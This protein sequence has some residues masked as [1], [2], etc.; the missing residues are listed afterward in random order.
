MRYRIIADS[1]CDLPSDF[2]KD[3]GIDFSVVPLKISI[4]GKEFV[5]DDTLDIKAFINAMRL[6]KNT[7][8]ACPSPDAFCAEFKK[9]MHSICITISQMLSGTY[10]SAVLGAS[11]A[12][13]ENPDIKAEVVDSYLTSGGMILMIM[14]LKEYIK[15][16]LDYEAIVEKIKEYQK[17]ICVR[18]VLQ[19]LGNLVKAG[20]MS[21]VA[22]VFASA[23][24]LCPICG[25]NTKGEIKVFEKVRGSK[26]A[27]SHLADTVKEKL[28]KEKDFPVIITHCDNEEQAQSLKDMLLERYGLKNV[29]IFPQR[30]LASFYAAYKGLIMAF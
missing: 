29:S 27:I 23:L 5:D 26:A 14:K 21:R 22:G 25:D 11:L 2:L 19:D 13:E 16:G 1:S 9:N 4:D 20:R 7:G 10:S 6:G 8:T 28:E 17:T 15:E 12:K 24:S 30:G 3:D 18:F